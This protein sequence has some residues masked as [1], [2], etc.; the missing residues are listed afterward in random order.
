M[1]SKRSSFRDKNR[2]S[3]QVTLWFLFHIFEADT[4]TFPTNRYETFRLSPYEH[5]SIQIYWFILET[6]DCNHGIQYSRYVASNLYI[7][8]IPSYSHR[9]FHAQDQIH[10]HI[11]LSYK[12]SLTSE[13]YNWGP[14]LLSSNHSFFVPLLSFE[15]ILSAV[16]LSQNILASL[17][18]K[19]TSANTH[20]RS[21]I[22][23]IH[24]RN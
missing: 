3:N 9:I 5:V 12:A 23:F 1:G 6:S 14:S 8:E 20:N 19:T 13:G 17:D 11:L 2:F 22:Y 24:A 7:F 18:H 10:V 21:L 16:T 15:I 4:Q